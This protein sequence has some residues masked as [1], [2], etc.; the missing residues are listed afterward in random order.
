[1]PLTKKIAIVTGATAGIGEATA[2]ALVKA[3]A[4][5]VISGRRKEKLDAVAGRLNSKGGRVLAV[6]SDASKNAD[7]DELIEE[8]AIVWSK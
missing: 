5:V 1:M 7:T 8:R 2:E 4:Y 3:G 6:R